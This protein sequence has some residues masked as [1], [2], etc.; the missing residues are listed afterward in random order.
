[1]T[2]PARKIIEQ[3]TLIVDLGL[4]G[5]N[6]GIFLMRERTARCFNINLPEER[7]CDLEFSLIFFNKQ[8]ECYRYERP[9]L[10][11]L[12][13]AVTALTGCGSFIDWHF[14]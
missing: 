2:A 6:S 13:L 12:E 4:L 8:S 10:L 11:L 7:D 1:M 9:C 14:T 5:A 3:F